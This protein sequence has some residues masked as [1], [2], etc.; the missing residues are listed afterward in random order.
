MPNIVTVG[1]LSLIRGM[2][3]SHAEPFDPYFG[4]GV[5]LQLISRHRGVLRHRGWIP[6]YSLKTPGSS[7]CAQDTLL[8]VPH[9]LFQHVVNQCLCFA[10]SHK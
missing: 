5:L 1:R 3:E 8:Q 4:P 2:P 9:P 7:V 10:Q 6:H